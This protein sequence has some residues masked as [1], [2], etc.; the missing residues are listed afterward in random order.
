MD[1]YK[2]L[3]Q[4]PTLEDISL[5]N[6][7]VLFRR[8]SFMKLVCCRSQATAYAFLQIVQPLKIPL[9][10]NSTS[11]MRI[12]YNVEDDRDDEIPLKKKH[13]LNINNNFRQI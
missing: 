2:K 9:V 13:K 10:E 7:G 6:F 1:K 5:T 11:K 4:L 8:I 3:I 12:I